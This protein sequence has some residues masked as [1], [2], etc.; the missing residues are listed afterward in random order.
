MIE[1]AVSTRL[2]HLVVMAQG[3]QKNPDVMRNLPDDGRGITAA[4]ERF[5]G[6]HAS[7]R[8]AGDAL[9][10]LAKEAA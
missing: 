2:G 7:P 6:A 1:N 8:L 5:P 10:T 4:L 3:Y 9:A